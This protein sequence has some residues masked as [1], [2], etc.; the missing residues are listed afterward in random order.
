MCRVM[1]SAACETQQLRVLCLM[2]KLGP[3][4]WPLECTRLRLWTLH[5]GHGC[6]AHTLQMENNLTNCAHSLPAC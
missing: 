2:W 4:T 1:R 3:E 6:N 5:Q